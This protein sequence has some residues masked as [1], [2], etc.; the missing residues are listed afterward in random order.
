MPFLFRLESSICQ[1]IPTF[2]RD[3]L[4]FKIRCIENTSMRLWESFFFVNLRIEEKKVK[5]HVLCVILSTISTA[6]N[7]YSF[8]VGWELT[9]S[10]CKLLVVEFYKLFSFNSLCD[11]FF[12]IL[13]GK[14]DWAR[15]RVCHLIAL[16]YARVDINYR[17]AMRKLSRK[18]FSDITRAINSDFDLEALWSLTHKNQAGKTCRCWSVSWLGAIL[19]EKFQK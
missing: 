10:M 6:A 13:W 15:V 18:H 1:K 19:S 16:I 5:Y 8:V 4:T 17:H 11:V 9:F 2:L 14:I 7:S 12:V 3:F